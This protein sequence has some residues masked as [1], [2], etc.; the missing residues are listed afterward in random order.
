M[1][2]DMRVYVGFYVVSAEVDIVRK[3][4][5]R[6]CTATDTCGRPPATSLAAFCSYCGA[7]IE[8][9]QVETPARHTLRPDDVGDG[10]WGEK[11]RAVNLES[12]GPA[13][14]LPNVAGFGDRF[15]EGSDGATA[16]DSA[17]LGSELTRFKAEFQPLLDAANEQYGVG[18]PI[19]FGAVAYW[20]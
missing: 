14:W 6:C 12:R 13:H 17:R 11:M 7:P 5:K 19:A 15:D 9:M 20:S 8:L 1:G 18:L 10:E 16:W 4:Q 3:S 2:M